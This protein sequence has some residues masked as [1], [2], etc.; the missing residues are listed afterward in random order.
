[1]ATSTH[2]IGPYSVACPTCGIE[3]GFMC[4]STRGWGQHNVPP[5]APRIAQL[6]AK[7]ALAASADKTRKGTR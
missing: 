2:R 1:M 3:A 4:V 6:R 5:H 7:E